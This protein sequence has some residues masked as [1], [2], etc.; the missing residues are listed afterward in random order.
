MV[1]ASEQIA[2]LLVSL[3]KQVHEKEEEL[4]R[5][6]VKAEE[7]CR[8]RE[9]E[10]EKDRERIEIFRFH[11]L[12]MRKAAKISSPLIPRMDLQDQVSLGSQS[13]RI[14]H[15]AKEILREAGEPIMQ[16][17]LLRRMEAKGIH[18]RAKNPVDL[19]RAALRRNPEFQHVHGKGWTLAE[20]A[21]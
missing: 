21:P 10:L 9:A 20:M 12:E 15:A 5:F 19:I 6:R 13:E 2:S 14:R 1:D 16:I 8:D 17:E 18:V 11:M 7:F 3:E 4:A